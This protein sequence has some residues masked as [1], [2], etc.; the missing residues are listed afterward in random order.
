[1]DVYAI[2]L[3]VADTRA[4]R[5]VVPDPEGDEEIALQGQYLADHDGAWGG[6]AAD[7]WP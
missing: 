4:D 6:L 5:F 7:D 3:I 2:S 1:V